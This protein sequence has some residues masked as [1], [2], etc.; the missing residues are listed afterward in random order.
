MHCFQTFGSWKSRSCVRVGILKL[1][2]FIFVC[3]FEV[4]FVGVLV[5]LYLFVNTVEIELES[6]CT[7]RLSLNP[8]RH[9]T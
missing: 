1:G 7:I 4:I 5:L 9:G 6:N 8:A 2:G 3:T